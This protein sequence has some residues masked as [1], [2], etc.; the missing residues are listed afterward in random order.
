MNEMIHLVCRIRSAD[1]V[2]EQK[3]RVQWTRNNHPILNV[4]E[5][6]SNYSSSESSL[7]ERLLIRKA[8]KTDTG[9][10][11][12]QYGPLLTATAHVIV[13]QSILI[14]EF[15]LNILQDLFPLTRSWC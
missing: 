1:A 9:I 11:A 13:Q 5:Y 6:F 4:A 15:I 3:L 2:N 7:Y 14:F 12:C 10:Y 8:R